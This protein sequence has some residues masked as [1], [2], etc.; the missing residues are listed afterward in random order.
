M[1]AYVLSLLLQLQR[2]ARQACLDW[3]CVNF[4]SV[5]SPSVGFKW[6]L[7]GL[8]GLEVT[9]VVTNWMISTETPERHVA[10]MT[11]LCVI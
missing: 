2:F 9:N 4:C 6:L 1:H 5:K 7:W 10:C 3:Q 8:P 11:L